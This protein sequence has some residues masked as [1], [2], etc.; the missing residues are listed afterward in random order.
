MPQHFRVRGV[1]VSTLALAML[2]SFIQLPS[3]DAAVSWQ[4]KGANI[5]SR[6][7][8]DFGSD[9]FKQSVRNLQSTGANYVSLVLPIYTSCDTCSDIYAGGDTPTD[10]ALTA[11]INYVHSLGM[12]VVL[13]PLLNS[14]SGWR[15]TIDTPDRDGWYRNYGN[16]LNHL[17]DIGNQTGVEGIVMGTELISMAAYTVHA[18]NTE[19]W[20]TMI[21]NLRQHFKGFL[22]YDAN[23]G[24]GLNSTNF[25]DEV[26]HIGFWGSLDYIGISA[27]YPLMQG[28]DNPSV[29]SLVGNWQ[30]WD[31]N[32][33]SQLS[34][35]YGKQLLFAEIG[36]VSTNGAHNAPCCTWNQGYNGTEQAN[37]Y[38][39]LFSYWAG[40]SELA[41]LFL[42]NWDSN[43]NYGGNGNQDYSPQNK[44]AQQVMTTWFNGSGTPMSG[45]GT[46]GGSTPPPGSQVSGSWTVSATSPS[47]NI[48]QP[49][50]ITTAVQ[51]SGNASNVIVDIEVYNSSGSKVFQQFFT[52]Q[53]ISSS[54]PGNYS[55]AWTP[56]QNDTYTLKVGIFTSDWSKNYYWNDA[57][58]PLSV[59]QN[60]AGGGAPSSGP[61]ATD[62]WWPSNGS[63]VSGIQPFKALVENKMLSNYTM[64]WQVDGDRLN[65]MYDSQTDAPH[66]EALVNLTNWN[67]K[68]SNSYTITFVSKDSAGTTI[69]Q[70]NA[71]INVTH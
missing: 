12:H 30:W 53:N 17:G 5:S 57:V 13:K 38:Q 43:P 9:S 37:D 27:Y 24:W 34:T 18:D 71:T 39:A 50:T 42:W 35:Q 31:Q 58:M 64:Y 19:R 6:W 47:L 33:L 23:W 48:D 2:S 8:D 65:Q 51:I 66:K 59:G 60:N 25:A 15:A 29:S 41:G 4:I 10:T 49:N 44:P 61:V 20:Q 3:A 55:T 52:G 54:Q 56:S 14:T 26:G 46:G 32:Q 11:G 67:W 70:K 40:S 45:G 21:T 69:S 63:S 68:A 7:S 36:Y 16:Y 28:T 22:T 62:V 1:L